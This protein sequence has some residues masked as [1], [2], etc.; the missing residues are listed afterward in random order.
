MIE[1]IINEEKKT[2]VAKFKR[3]DESYNDRDTWK[4]Y[5]MNHVWNLIEKHNLDYSIEHCIGRD[6]LGKELDKLDSRFY[7]IAHC[8]DKDAFDIDFGKELAKKRLLKKYYKVQ[9]SYE[10]KLHRIVD[11]IAANITAAVNTDRLKFVKFANEIDNMS[12]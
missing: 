4:H 3:Y 9:M 7:G 12:L 8:S 5:I 2:V 11:N 6:I 1:Y 10:K